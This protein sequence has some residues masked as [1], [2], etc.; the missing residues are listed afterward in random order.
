MVKSKGGHDASYEER[1]QVVMRT[2]RG[3]PIK[4]IARTMNRSPEFVRRW[5]DRKD[6]VL[7]EGN[8]QSKR[9]EKVGR[10]MRFSQKE[11]VKLAKQLN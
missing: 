3:S 11:S 2:M 6:E 5:R 10:K 1:L 7:R 8:L 4:R 9:K